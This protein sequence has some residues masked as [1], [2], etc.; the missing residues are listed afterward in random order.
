MAKYNTFLVLSTKGRPLL[1][2]S[3]ARKARKLLQTGVRVEVWSAN[4]KAETVYHRTRRLLDKYVNAE[5]E[6]IR[7]KQEAAERKNK[8]RR[9]TSEIKL[10]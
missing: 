6:Y 8:K 9:P 1:V 3:S 10:H 7:K 4:A 2:T 5:R